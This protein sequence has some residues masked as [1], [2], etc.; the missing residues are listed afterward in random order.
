MGQHLFA[1]LQVLAS[2]DSKI[3][4]YV[5]G[6]GVRPFTFEH[7]I[8]PDGT[9]SELYSRTAQMSVISALN[10]FNACLFVYGQT[11][12][13][14]TH[15]IFGPDGTLQKVESRTNTLPSDAGVALRALQEILTAINLKQISGGVRVCSIFATLPPP[16][17]YCVLQQPCVIC[18]H[19]EA[20]LLSGSRSCCTNS[21]VRSGYRHSILN[22][23]PIAYLVHCM[24]GDYQQ[25]SLSAKYIQIYQE[26]LTDLLSG[27]PV[28]LRGSRDGFVLQG[29]VETQLNTFQDAVNLLQ[30]GEANK[31]YAATTMNNHSS[32]AHTILVLSIQ[33]VGDKLR[34]CVYWH[35]QILTCIE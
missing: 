19:F 10:G 13:G 24:R 26:G 18:V 35:C 28:Q 22:T 6:Q 12:S 30:V 5:P 7:V 17:P 4:M 20:P 29:C 2:D 21:P 15:T 25:A 3:T 31:H 1:S 8:K 33:Q 14:K 11:G 23:A 34:G 27:A 9:Q 32:R 16:L